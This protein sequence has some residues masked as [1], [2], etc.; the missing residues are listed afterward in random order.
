MNVAEVAK[1]GMA[2]VSKTTGANLGSSNLSLRAI[3]IDLFSDNI[4]IS[5]FL[6]LSCNPICRNIN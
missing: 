2:V 6:A 1:P 3:F 4:I 5:K